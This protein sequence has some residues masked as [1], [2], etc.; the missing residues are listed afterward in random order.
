MIKQNFY[1]KSDKVNNQ[2][3]CP[4]YLRFLR[5][6]SNKAKDSSTVI[7]DE[8]CLVAGSIELSNLNAFVSDFLEVAKFPNYK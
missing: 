7:E 6:Q 8:S 4:I 5:N 1:L 2:E 3:E